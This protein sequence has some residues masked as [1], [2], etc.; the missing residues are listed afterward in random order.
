MSLSSL[1]W[2]A[3]CSEFLP[4]LGVFVPIEYACVAIGKEDVALRGEAN[5]LA[6]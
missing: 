1:D 3:F 2:P 4:T 6:L 5:W